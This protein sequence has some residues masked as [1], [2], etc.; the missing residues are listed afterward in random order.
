MELIACPLFKCMDDPYQWP[1]A[2]YIRR[3]LLDFIFQII[4]KMISSSFPSV[5][6]A[7]FI[8]QTLNERSKSERNQSKKKWK[9]N[10]SFFD[11][12]FT[13]ESQQ[14]QQPWQCRLSLCDCQYHDIQRQMCTIRSMWNKIDFSCFA[15]LHWQR[16]QSAF[17]RLRCDN[18]P[19]I[20][21]TIFAVEQR[22]KHSI[23]KIAYWKQNAIIPWGWVSSV[24][25]TAL[26][27]LTR[28]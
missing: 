14:Q 13:T 6:W 18:K 5:E 21:K 4:H 28:C 8:E 2:S 1:F 24:R 9:C 20:A 25:I 22:Q 27:Q 11:D 12:D 19:N 23:V 16:L 15:L 26:V 10:D 3:D 17:I 7:L